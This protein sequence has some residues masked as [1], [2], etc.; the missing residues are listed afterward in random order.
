[1]LD[2]WTCYF[3]EGREG[4]EEVIKVP[5]DSS[6]RGGVYEST[7]EP[8]LEFEFESL[9]FQHFLASRV[10]THM[11]A[12]ELYKFT[13]ALVTGLPKTTIHITMDIF[14]WPMNYFYYR[15][16]LLLFPFSSFVFVL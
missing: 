7:G 1:M 11:C 3:E 5:V 13:T 9:Q 15:H 12:T 10:S 2:R 6:K 4:V 14:E 16:R 8:V